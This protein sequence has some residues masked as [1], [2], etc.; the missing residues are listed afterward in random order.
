MTNYE[1]LKN[2]SVELIAEFLEDIFEDTADNAISK[3]FQ[4]EYCDKC[5]T[6]TIVGCIENPDLAGQEWHE[7][8]FEGICPHYKNDKDKIML[9][10]ESEA[11]E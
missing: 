8:E 3:W 2:A 7:C 11:E 5:P 9:W 6:T 10:L 1:I 4:E